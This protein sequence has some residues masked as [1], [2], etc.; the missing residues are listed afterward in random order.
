[1]NIQKIIAYW[2]ESSKRDFEVA[3][4]LFKKKHYSYCLFFCHLTLEKILKAL[5]VKT[6][7]QQAPYLHDLRK[8]AERAELDSSPKQFTRLDKISTFNIAGRYN[9]FKLKFYK[10]CTK[11]FTKKYLQLSKKLYQCFN[12]QLKN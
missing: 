9:D 12:K 1:M 8:L 6:T 5:V 10:K 7:K 11:V 4:D 3:K 2:V